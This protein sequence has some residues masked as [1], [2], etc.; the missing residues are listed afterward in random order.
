M[1]ILYDISFAIGLIE[2]LDQPGLF[3]EVQQKLL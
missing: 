1:K 3:K 2:D